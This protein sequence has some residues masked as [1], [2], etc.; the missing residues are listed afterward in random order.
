MS[1]SNFRL[2]SSTIVFPCDRFVYVSGVTGPT[3][4]TGPI[5]PTG[6]VGHTG[7]T[8]P[9]GASGTLT[10]P[11]GPLGSFG[12]SGNTGPQGPSGP[13]GPSIISY[14]GHTGPVGPTGPTAVGSA[15]T[16]PTG[17]TGPIGAAGPASGVTGTYV[18]VYSIP[19]GPSGPTG[20][21]GASAIPLNTFFVSSSTDIVYN[22]DPG[23]IAGNVVSAGTITVPAGKYNF[24]VRLNL[25]TL[26][27]NSSDI[28]QIKLVMP[29]ISTLTTG[30][31]VHPT[32]TLINLTTTINDQYTGVDSPYGLVIKVVSVDTASGTAI[33]HITNPANNNGGNLEGKWVL[34]MNI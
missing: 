5:G 30:N 34:V 12:P 8:G 6:P 23:S 1:N 10:G 2:G 7:P 3:G 25:P 13:T 29:G 9:A 11:T 27:Y 33:Y 26:N 19:S 17:P 14:T 22:D 18:Q 20:V 15:G 28:I 21:T 32:M 31:Y 4:P 16:G 24:S